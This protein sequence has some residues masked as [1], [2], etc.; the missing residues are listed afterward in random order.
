ML[1]IF[2]YTD[3]SHLVFCTFH[4]FCFICVHVIFLLKILFIVI[5]Y[6]LFDIHIIFVVTLIYEW[7]LWY[8]IKEFVNRLFIVQQHKLNIRIFV[9][10]ICYQITPPRL[11][12]CM[13]CSKNPYFPYQ[14]WILHAFGNIL[15][16]IFDIYNDNNPFIYMTNIFA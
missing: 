3:R 4:I 16:Y 6:F 13:D 9:Q 10:N 11:V 8:F 5:K 15:T 2:V 12:G 14:H 7:Y 1:Y